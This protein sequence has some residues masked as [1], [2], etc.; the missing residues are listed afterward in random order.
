MG[1]LRP[2]R[3]HMH[4]TRQLFE[5][6]K[7]PLPYTYRDMHAHQGATAHYILRARYKCLGPNRLRKTM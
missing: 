1:S 2:N 3:L 7:P 4:A 5:L 6:L